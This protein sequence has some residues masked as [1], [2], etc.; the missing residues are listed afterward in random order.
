MINYPIIVAISGASGTVY[1][2]RLLQ[3]LL[4]NNYKVELVFSESA[5]KVAKNETNLNL[6]TNPDV[7]KEQVL[8]YLQQLELRTLLNIW[9]F[10]DI[11]ASISSGSY[12]TA[13]MIIIPA[14]MGTIS[15]VANGTSD[16]LITR[17][18][19]VCIKEKRKLVLVPRE[20]PFS[21]I[22]LENLLKLSKLGAIVAPACPGFYHKPN[23]VNEMIDFVVGKVLDL[24]EIE[25]DL[26]KRWEKTKKEIKSV[27]N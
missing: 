18:A 17:A 9:S 26:F 22:H 7:L 25:H 6:S 8:S 15:G 16:N 27:V 10:D 13:G 1:G 12:K 5:I 20:M 21:P 3:F 24:F 4:S 2:L 11:A 19:D 23:E 14:S